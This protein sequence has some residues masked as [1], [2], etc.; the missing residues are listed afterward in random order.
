MS[1][2]ILQAG[3]LVAARSGWTLTNLSLQKIIYIAHMFHLGTYDD[4]LVSGDFE[5]WDLGPVHPDLYHHVKRFGAGPVTS[6]RT[7][8]P[9]TGREN[10]ISTLSEAFDVLGRKTPGQLVA[11]THWS[12][13]AWAKNYVRGIRSRIIPRSDIVNEYHARRESRRQTATE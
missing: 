10:E 8:M 3:K 6:I 12:K 9:S 4:T 5:A 2:D 13:G 7:T 11:I 1:I